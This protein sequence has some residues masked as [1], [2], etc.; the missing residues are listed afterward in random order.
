MFVGD[1]VNDANV[2]SILVV[3]ASASLAIFRTATNLLNGI[4]L[5]SLYIAQRV[6]IFA[7]AKIV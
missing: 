1:G 2:G 3:L 4:Q 6:C 7:R 5:E